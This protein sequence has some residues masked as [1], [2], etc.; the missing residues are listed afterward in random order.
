MM[1]A[2][3][4]KVVLL[5]LPQSPPLPDDSTQPTLVIHF[6]C[7]AHVNIRLQD[8]AQYYYQKKFVKAN[9]IVALY[10]KL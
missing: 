3:S 4:A 7:L 6:T 9:L 8:F 1:T 5:G 10:L 2:A